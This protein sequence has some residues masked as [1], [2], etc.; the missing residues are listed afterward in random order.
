MVNICLFS[1]QQNFLEQNKVT[2]EGIESKKLHWNK[3]TVQILD[4]LLIGYFCLQQKRW[5]SKLCDKFHYTLNEIMVFSL[6]LYPM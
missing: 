5:E 4:K 3:K 2:L 6:S 1:H